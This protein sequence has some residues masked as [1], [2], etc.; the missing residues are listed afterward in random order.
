MEIEAS[1]PSAAPQKVAADITRKSA[2]N[3]WFVGQALAPERRRLFEAS[4]ATMRLIDD[5]VDD[6]FLARSDVEREASRSSAQGRIEAWRKAC[7]SA[8]A[9]QDADVSGGGG[10]VEEALA[11]QALQDAAALS[12]VPDAPWCR[13]ADAMKFDVCEKRLN[14]WEDFEAYCEGATVAPAAIFLFVLQAKRQQ[15]TLHAGLTGEALAAQA[16]DMAIF[17]YLVHIVR[18]FAK[19]V[20]KGGQLVTIPLDALTRHTLSRESI[21]GDPSRAMPVLRDLV[22]RAAMYRR[23]ARLMADQLIPEMGKAEGRILDALL[24]IYERLHDGLMEN[25]DPRIDRSSVTSKL[26]K[27]LMTKLGLG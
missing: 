23:D 18:D 15:G 9:G 17:C 20:E 13:L 1:K 8:I 3:L 4:Y 21:K 19:D 12:D 26:R 14:T 27:S 16:R 24:S 2:S 7:Q 22:D 6:D 10:S 25:P 11:V 5:F